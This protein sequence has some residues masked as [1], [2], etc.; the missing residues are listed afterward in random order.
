MFRIEIEGEAEA[1]AVVEAIRGIV[2]LRADVVEVPHGTIP[3]NAKR[4]EDRR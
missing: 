3:A 2:R 1:D 4:L